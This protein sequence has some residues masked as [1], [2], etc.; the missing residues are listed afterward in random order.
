MGVIG[1]PGMGKTQLVLSIMQDLSEIKN[2]DDTSSAVFVFDFKGEFS[3]MDEF[4]KLYGFSVVNVTEP[5][6]FD[7]WALPDAL[8]NDKGLG[9]K[10]IQI[11]D[12]FQSIYNIGPAQKF[13]LS[14]VLMD[15]YKKRN[16]ASPS[17]SDI[18]SGYAKARGAGAADTVDSILN[19]FK[20]TGAFV[21]DPNLHNIPAM[22]DYLISGRK[23][24][25]FQLDLIASPEIIRFY[26]TVILNEYNQLMMSQPNQT[27]F[28]GNLRSLRSVLVVDE[29]HNLMQHKPKSLGTIQSM[30][31]AKG[32]GLLMA[33]QQLKH[34]RP[35]PNVNYANL[36]DTWVFFS[37]A[38][39]TK[40]DLNGVGAGPEASQTLLAAINQLGQGHAAFLTPDKKD[41]DWGTAQQYWRRK[42]GLD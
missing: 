41:G 27:V 38:G 42:E 12:T 1:K 29:A 23:I 33:S 30:G 10:I 15:Q 8:K 32:F 37:S 36:M 18:A 13:R 25:N 4:N 26:A 28:P 7:I 20:L 14:E 39:L 5:V 35:D 11:C 22:Q 40:A 24:F 34:F 31:R 9:Q 19:Q 6:P 3:V 2:P 21:P 16:F 17:L